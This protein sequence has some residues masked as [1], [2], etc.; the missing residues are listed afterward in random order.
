MTTSTVDT[1]PHHVPDG[2][3]EGAAAERSPKQTVRELTAL[4]MAQEARTHRLEEEAVALNR[5]LQDVESRT[6]DLQKRMQDLL[7][8]LDEAIS[9]N[10]LF[11][12]YI[13]SHG[14]TQ[15]FKQFS[16]RLTPVNG[17]VN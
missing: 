8:R 7:S 4:L 2:A 10:N 1:P 9:L 17:K 3:Q 15:D 6:E 16:E 11:L 14:L 5:R 13:E 12:A